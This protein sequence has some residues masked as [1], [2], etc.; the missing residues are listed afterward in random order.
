MI[1]R[2]NVNYETKLLIELTCL[3]YKKEFKKHREEVSHFSKGGL[4]HEWEKNK[5]KGE[6]NERVR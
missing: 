1:K 5:Y 3:E 6:R 2:L 4:Y